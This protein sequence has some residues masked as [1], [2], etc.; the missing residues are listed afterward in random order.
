[1]TTKKT[2]AKNVKLDAKAKW[3]KRV[4]EAR[5]KDAAFRN[6]VEPYRFYGVSD[7]FEPVD[8]Y[9]PRS[10]E[11]FT[12]L[13]RVKDP[14]VPLTDGEMRDVLRILCGPEAWPAIWPEIKNEHVQLMF[15]LLNEIDEHFSDITALPSADEVDDVPGGA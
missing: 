5:A 7:D 10:I 12:V 2:P 9:P 3:R 13:A 14:N 11:Q 6:E 15:D 8:I 4:E 1:M